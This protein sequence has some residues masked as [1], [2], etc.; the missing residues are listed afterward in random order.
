M[1]ALL[2]YCAP[3]GDQSV[4]RHPL[5]HVSYRGELCYVVVQECYSIALS[6]SISP[7]LGGQ[8]SLLR[9]LAFGMQG[10]PTLALMLITVACHIKAQNL[11]RVKEAISLAYEVCGLHLSAFGHTLPGVWFPLK[12]RQ[13]FSLACLVYRSQCVIATQR[14]VNL[15]KRTFWVTRVTL[16][17][18]IGN[19]MLHLL[20]SSRR[21]RQRP[22]R[23]RNLRNRWRIRQYKDGDVRMFKTASVPSFNELVWFYKGLRQSA[24][25]RVVLYYIYI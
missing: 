9:R 14:R 11:S 16:V 4:G 20:P 17:F 19:E 25:P 10:P 22:F 5:I 6:P 1:A 2:A 7:L 8:D 15:W 3:L 13:R 18:W 24:H 23:Q 12:L 21:C